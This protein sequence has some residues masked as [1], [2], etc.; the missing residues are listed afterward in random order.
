MANRLKNKLLYIFISLV[1]LLCIA[2]FVSLI[3]VSS[4]SKSNVK[5]TAQMENYKFKNVL[6]DS[7]DLKVEYQWIPLDSIS[8]NLVIAI[9]ASEDK[10]FYVH[11][12]F[13]SRQEKDSA[14]VLANRGKTISQKVAN[15]VFLGKGNDDKKSSLLENYFTILIEYMWNKDRIL[16]VYLNTTS[17]GH[18][19]FGAEAG[20][21]IYF[22]KSAGSLTREQAAFLAYLYLYPQDTVVEFD[23][24]G[25][26]ICSFQSDVLMKMGMMTQLKIGKRPVD[27]S[28]L[29]PQKTIY[30]RNWR[31]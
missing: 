3:W 18:G 2:F 19:I 14:L 5:I 15:S 23:F 27:E 25:E 13:F 29:M 9:L 4:Y 24:P 22:N 7:L 10:D 8:R 31:G 11:D 28:K 21:Q 6:S 1:V 12:G 20:S 16:E 17:L 30:K 26:R